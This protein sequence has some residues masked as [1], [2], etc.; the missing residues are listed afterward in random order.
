MTIANGTTYNDAT[1]QDVINALET[2]RQTR[3][4]IR[5]FYGDVQTGKS[6]DEY[7]DVMG[8]VGRS[9]GTVKIPLLIHNTRSSGGCG[10]LDHCIIR[11]TQDSG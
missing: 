6:W 7:N 8:T 3:S 2:A 10:I 5:V 11:I 9:T 4:R 1:A